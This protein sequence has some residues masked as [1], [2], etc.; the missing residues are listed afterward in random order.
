MYTIPPVV[1]FLIFIR[2]DCRLPRM[3][4]KQSEHDFYLYSTS[5]DHDT[6]TSH[7]L[8]FTRRQSPA[9]FAIK[10]VLSLVNIVSIQ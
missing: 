2:S 1:F 8:R 6:P 10:V 7:F 3:D 4:H 5:A 9:P